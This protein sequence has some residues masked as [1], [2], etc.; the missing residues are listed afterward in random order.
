MILATKYPWRVGV[1]NFGITLSEFLFTATLMLI[2]LTM[3][4]DFVSPGYFNIQSRTIV[5]WINTSFILLI[6]LIRFICM[7]FEFNILK[8]LIS[9]DS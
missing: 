4:L 2:A 6:C 1:V 3:Y 7:I 8:L 5:G 9:N